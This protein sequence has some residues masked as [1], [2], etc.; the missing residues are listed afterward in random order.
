MQSA[1]STRSSSQSRPVPVIVR[2]GEG[3]KVILTGDFTGWSRDGIP[4]KSMGAGKYR[5]N[6]E[7]PPGTYQF[8][9]LVDGEWSDDLDGGHRVPNSFGSENSVL[10]VS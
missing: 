5:A 2:A 1:K 3:K 9:I 4:M 6:L 10:E 7:L 8:R